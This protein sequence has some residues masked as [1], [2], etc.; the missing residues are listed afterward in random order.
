MSKTYGPMKITTKGQVTIPGE[1][2]AELGLLPH[3][4]VEFEVRG[5]EAVIRK[6][7]TGKGEPDRPRGRA[8]VEHLERHARKYWKSDL[9]TDEIMELM[10]GPPPEV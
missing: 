8:I 7:G 3:T 9:T 4:Q 6:A 5:G 10:R 2:R 1:I